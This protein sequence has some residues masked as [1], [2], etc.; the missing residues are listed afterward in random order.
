MSIAASFDDLYHELKTATSN[1]INCNLVKAFKRLSP[2]YHP[3]RPTSNE[4]IWKLFKRAATKFMTQLFENEMNNSKTNDYNDFEKMAEDLKKTL[5]PSSLEQ[6]YN[7]T[8]IK[9]REIVVSH[10]NRKAIESLSEDRGL[11][12]EDTM[13]RKKE[14]IKKAKRKARLQEEQKARRKPEP[15][16]PG[17]VSKQLYL[18]WNEVLEETTE[19]NV[20][21]DQ[22]NG[23]ETR[24]KETTKDI[25]PLNQPLTQ[26]A[27]KR[28]KPDRCQPKKNGKQGKV[29]KMEHDLPN[30]LTET[31]SQE[32]AQLKEKGPHPHKTTTQG[33]FP[34]GTKF[35]SQKQIMGEDYQ[36]Q[37]SI[38]V[39]EEGVAAI[40]LHEIREPLFFDKDIVFFAARAK[41]IKELKTQKDTV[42]IYI[43]PIGKKGWVLYG[44]AVVSSFYETPEPF[45]YVTAPSDK[46]SHGTAKPRLYM[47]Q[48]QY[49]SKQF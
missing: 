5:M 47:V 3:D 31:F 41:Y 20:A 7:A 48:L 17:V 11:I 2:R 15:V 8:V 36:K 27:P 34:T 1:T 13:E 32:L 19:D 25:I 4:E 24:T 40:F 21:W 18:A 42:P 10:M 38:Y 46:K 39:N 26:H 6:E 29:A 16:N 37:T 33:I 35:L 45:D 43:M 22:Q 14:E 30:E 44:N 28:K 23:T 49:V 9:N 12:D